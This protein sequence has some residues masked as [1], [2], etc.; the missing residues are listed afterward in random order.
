MI[1][2]ADGQRVYMEHWQ[3]REQHVRLGVEPAAEQCVKGNGK[4]FRVQGSGF[5]VRGSGLSAA[6]ASE[7]NQRW[8][9]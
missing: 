1:E 5:G 8:W 2:E 6:S 3:R 7:Y 4:G 9:V